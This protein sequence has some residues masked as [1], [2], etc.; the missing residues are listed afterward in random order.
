MGQ[1]LKEK[2]QKDKKKSQMGKKPTKS[3]NVKNTLK[4][5]NQF[6]KKRCVKTNCN[7]KACNQKFKC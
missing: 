4:Y 7:S 5:T 3:S 6:Q 2:H 1:Y